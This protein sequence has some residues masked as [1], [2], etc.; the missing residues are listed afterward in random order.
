V[1]SGTLVQFKVEHLA[2]AIG[3]LCTLIALFAPLAEYQNFLL[4]IGSVFA[5]LFGVVLVDHFI[6]R[7]R[8]LPTGIPLLRWDSL[9]AWLCGV[10]TFHLLVNFYPAIGATLPALLL[11]GV[12]QLLLGKLRRS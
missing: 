11:A 12:L 1:S 3:A 7:R 10:T 8:Q 9:L 6:L 5:P 2:L 4:L